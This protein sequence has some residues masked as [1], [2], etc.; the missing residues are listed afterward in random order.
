MAGVNI[1]F[2]GIE[3]GQLRLS[4][5]CFNRRVC[6]RREVRNKRIF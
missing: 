5:L 6:F 3:E 1:R 2:T 4:L